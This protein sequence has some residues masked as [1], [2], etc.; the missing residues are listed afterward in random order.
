[1]AS[2]IAA[3]NSRSVRSASTRA[4]A[5]HTNRPRRPRDRHALALESIRHFLKARS[6]Y[7]VL[8]VSFRLIV[9]DTQLVVGP[10]LDVIS[11]K[12]GFAGMLTVND[13]IHLIQYYYHHSSYETAKA[14]VESFRLE[15]L[16]DIEAKL[17]VPP[18]PLLSCHPL[19]PLFE[20]CQLLMKTHAR[21]LPLLDHDEQTGI[22]TVVSVLTQYR[23][24]K[25]IAM[26]CRETASLHR[27]LRYLDLGTFV[28]SVKTGPASLSTSLPNPTPGPTSIP[29]TTSPSSPSTNPHHPLYTATLNTTVF[30]VVHMFS[31]HGISAVPIL[32]EE[33]YAVDMYESVDVITLVRSG[34]YQSLDLTIRQALERRPADFP[35]VYACSPED[36]VANIFAL[37]R[38]KR[39]HRLLIV[40][41]D[42]E[43]EDAA[44]LPTRGRLVGILALSDLLRHIIGMDATADT[45]LGSSAV[46][47]ETVVETPMM[48]HMPSL[49]ASAERVKREGAEVKEGQEDD[50]MEP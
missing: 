22:E 44:P 38:K 28:A 39:V 7:D 14:E 20:A 33:G 31:E 32:D 12:P 5:S 36:S 25:F 42:E 41:P 16:R 19:R 27:S 4:S 6:T 49:A 45:S 18:P 1:M 24:L 43:P 8:P 30:D 10:A 37:L 13:I 46:A 50:G 2:S 15:G 23:V 47:D 40:E 34:A 26:N 3:G 29:R 35:G 9:L 21:R 17:A 48:E 11:V